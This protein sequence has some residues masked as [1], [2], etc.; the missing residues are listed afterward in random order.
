MK[1][2]NHSLPNNSRLLPLITLVI[3]LIFTLYSWH[4]LINSDSVNGFDAMKGYDSGRVNS[5]HCFTYDPELTASGKV[6][7]LVE[8]RTIF[9]ALDIYEIAAY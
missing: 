9:S 8:P 6:S 2:L 1:G 3:I 4:Q 7:H 5:T